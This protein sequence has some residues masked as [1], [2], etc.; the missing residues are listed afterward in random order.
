MFGGV[1]REMGTHVGAVYGGLC[2]MGD[3]FM[4]LSGLNY[5]NWGRVAAGFSGLLA[6][7][8]PMFFLRRKMDPDSSHPQ[9][10]AY[11]EKFKHVWKFWKYPLEFQAAVNL[12]QPIIMAVASGPDTLSKLGHELG[13]SSTDR[14]RPM[15]SIVGV[16]GTLGFMIM[17]LNQHRDT[18][19][20]TKSHLKA[21]PKLKA[22]WDAVKGFSQ[23]RVIDLCSEGHR[24]DISMK[25]A[26]E[27]AC[28]EIS[29]AGPN[30]V[31]AKIFNTVVYPW[32]IESCLLQDWRNAISGC[33]YVAAN[34]VLTKINRRADTLDCN[35]VST[36]R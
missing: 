17:L 31:A 2:L 15:E 8:A 21:F 29:I 22:D 13:L 19:V 23:R 35:R 26:F 34:H 5:S 24:I 4:G 20:N 36:P 27:N 7:C 30:Q 28:L 18:V 11:I 9:D 14:V 33:C 25:K 6:N 32:I 3:A 10:I 12:I 16:G 1:S